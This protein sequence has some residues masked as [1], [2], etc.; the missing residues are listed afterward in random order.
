MNIDKIS[1][2]CKD[3]SMHYK[4]SKNL[5]K[6]RVFKSRASSFLN[7][8]LIISIIT[9]SGCHKRDA[10]RGTETQK[11]EEGTSI[12]RNGVNSEDLTQMKPELYML[13][14]GAVDA[15]FFYN[16]HDYRSYEPL[17]RETNYNEEEDYY[18]HKCRYRAS[19]LEGGYETEEKVFKV[20]LDLEKEGL[21][22]YRVEDI[23]GKKSLTEKE[24]D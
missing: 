20:W 5:M 15:W 13:V 14:E 19:T 12:E 1:N 3:K 10:G 2:G 16:L 6:A 9:L 24:E 17:I 18:I 4:I 11:V 23:A 22:D 8:C 21:K 7:L